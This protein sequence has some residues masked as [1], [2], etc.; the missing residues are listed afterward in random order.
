MKRI[1]IILIVAHLISC[2]Q[3]EDKESYW[4]KYAGGRDIMMQEQDFSAKADLDS[5][6]NKKGLMALGPIENLK[7]EITIF[8]GVVYTGTIENDHAVYRKDSVVKAVFLAYGSADVYSAVEVEESI[9]GLKNIE[10]YIRE[11]A[12]EK[13]L[14]LEKSFPFYM[15][16]QVEDLDYHIM[17]KEGAGMHGPQAHQKAK[18]KFKLEKS[19]AKIVGVWANSQEEGLYTH[20]GSRAHLHFVNENSLAS[21]HIDD[22]QILAGTKLFLPQ[23]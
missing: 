14:D 16:A 5:L 9:K 13:G 7:G 1:F 3:S 23:N 10:S 19:N 22:V 2:S 17:F 15:E 18:R 6:K 8:N 20:K 12:T 21:G 11:K 4:L